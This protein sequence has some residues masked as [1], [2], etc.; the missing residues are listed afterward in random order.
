MLR[1]QCGGTRSA[2]GGDRPDDED[3]GKVICSEVNIAGGDP[4][5]ASWLL[6]YGIRS[7]CIRV[8]AGQLANPD[9]GGPARERR[10]G[11]ELPKRSRLPVHPARERP[12]AAIASALSRNESDPLVRLFE[13]RPL[14]SC[15]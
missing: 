2:L 12:T 15:Q 14:L 6:P 4:G 10:A 8:N 1:G 7:G 5:A 3:V 9:R 13:L 11:W